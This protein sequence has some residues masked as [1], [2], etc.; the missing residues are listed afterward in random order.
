MSNQVAL[1]EPVDRG[2]V[3]AVL[4]NGKMSD[5]VGFPHFDRLV[6]W[7]SRI[8]STGLLTLMLGEDEI[9]VESHRQYILM[10]SITWN[11]QII[12]KKDFEANYQ[13]VPIAEEIKRRSPNG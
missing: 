3:H 2:Q 1:Y 12:D 8:D 4:W 9:K 6:E 13:G 5:L 7:V 10:D 11:I